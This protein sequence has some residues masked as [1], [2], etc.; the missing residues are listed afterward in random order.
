MADSTTEIL[1][2]SCRKLQMMLYKEKLF[3]IHFT[4]YYS[5]PGRVTIMRVSDPIWISYPPNC[6][7]SASEMWRICGDQRF[8]KKIQPKNKAPLTSRG[9]AKR[10]WAAWAKS[11]KCSMHFCTSPVPSGASSEGQTYDTGT[12]WNCCDCPCMHCRSQG[13]NW[14]PWDWF[15]GSFHLGNPCYQPLRDKHSLKK[16]LLIRTVVGETPQFS[17][18]GDN[19]ITKWQD[20]LNS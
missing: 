4:S 17:A 20:P 16:Y 5:I 7:V 6:M 18:V 15:L 9:L 8:A 14:S 1:R 12:P 3:A 10:P 13:K 11:L 19:S 2:E